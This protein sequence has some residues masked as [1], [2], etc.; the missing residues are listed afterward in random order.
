MHLLTAKP[1]LCNLLKVPIYFYVF[2]YNRVPNKLSMVWTRR[3]RRVISQPMP[4]EPTLQQPLKGL[5]IWPVPDNQQV[6]VTLFK[7]PRNE[8]EDK[9]WT[10]VIEDVSNTYKLSSDQYLSILYELLNNFLSVGNV[11]F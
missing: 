3:S 10:F 4:W 7:D 8:L 5:V 9:D 11:P 6:S 1:Q 2:V